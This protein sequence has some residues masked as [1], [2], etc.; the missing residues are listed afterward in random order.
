MHGEREGMREGL[1]YREGSQHGI[2]RVRGGSRAL[3]Q[4]SGVYGEVEGVG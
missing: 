3:Q 1:G 4:K 2:G